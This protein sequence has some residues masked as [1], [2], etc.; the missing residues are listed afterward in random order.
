[1]DYCKLKVFIDGTEAKYTELTSFADTVY[2]VVKLGANGPLFFEEHVARL[3]TS[4]ELAGVSEKIDP[5]LLLKDTIKLIEVNGKLNANV[6][7]RIDYSGASLKRLVY[8]TK[9]NY[10]ASLL[11]ELGAFVK[12]VDFVRENPKS[13]RFTES[14]IDL[15]ERLKADTCYE[16][17]LLDE[18]GLIKEGA[19]S[20]V[21]FFK[22]CVVYTAGNEAVLSGITRSKVIDFI[23]SK[24]TLEYKALSVSDLNDM[25]GAFL[26]GTSPGVLPIS[27]IDKINYDMSNFDICFDIK[28]SYD[29]A[30]ENYFRDNDFF[31]DM[32]LSRDYFKREI[33]LI[34][35]DSFKKL[36]RSSVMV[37]GLGGV[38]S[39]AGEAIAR[40]GVGRIAV[41]DY[42]IIEES[43]INRQLLALNSSLG[44]KKTDLMAARIK[45][46][47][48]YCMVETMDF[49]LDASN[50]ETVSDF[51]PDY[52]VDAIDSFDSKLAL[53]SFAQGRG[54][55]II[56]CMGTGGKLNPLDLEVADI[57]KTTICPLA[58]KLRHA[59]RARGVDKLKVLYSKEK[60]SGAFSDD[61]GIPSISF[62][63][64]VAGFAL[65]SEA[66]KY[67]IDE[68]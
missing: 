27:K 1:M 57:F 21:F 59:L 24:Y 58:R 65:A 33:A 10:T 29:E 37:V 60:S 7:Y 19:K 64:P 35:M 61:G 55:P 42:D 26:T 30:V 62:V 51:D 16:Y 9:S 44:M 63:P 47:N 22:D 18:D 12:S 3:N 49:R 68:E 4:L 14:M 67:L 46:I 40:S 54:I 15:R 52:I 31:I 17:L 5:C 13:K 38:G 28:K 6:T 45:D 48:P 23:K 36:R 43:N 11:Y 41:C 8:Y 32:E 66:I 39:A 25:D 56:S 20:N 34:G 2:E 50:M 53:I